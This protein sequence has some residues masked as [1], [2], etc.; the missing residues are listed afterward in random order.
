MSHISKI[1]LEVKDLAVLSQ[2]CTRLGIEFIR[3]Q[4]HFKWYGEEASCDHVIKV[5]GAEYEIGVIKDQ[6]R[7]DLSCDF[8]DRALE[9]VIGRQGGL[10]KQAY[11]VSK[12]KIEARRKGYSVLEKNTDTGVRLHIRLHQ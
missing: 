11:A 4:K 1:E 9:K 3:G 6:S 8:Y 12:T 2:A 7:Y 5:P 10:L